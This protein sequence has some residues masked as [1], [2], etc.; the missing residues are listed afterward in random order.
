MRSTYCI[1]S[2]TSTDQ[3]NRSPINMS[4]TKQL[5]SFAKDT[6]FKNEKV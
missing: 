1:N 5:Y 3:I 2:V 4:L 6:R